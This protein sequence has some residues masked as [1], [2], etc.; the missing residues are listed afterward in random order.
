MVFAI[1]FPSDRNFNPKWNSPLHGVSEGTQNKLFQN[2]DTV[3]SG[4]SYLKKNDKVLL[5]N[6]FAYNCPRRGY[7]F[8]G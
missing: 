4:L 2:V 3:G 1:S 6:R 8:E 5:R 7:V